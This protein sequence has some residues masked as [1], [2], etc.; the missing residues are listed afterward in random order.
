MRLL[1]ASAALSAARAFRSVPEEAAGFLGPFFAQV[2][3][4]MR[5]QPEG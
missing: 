2:A 5:N 3:D 4:F 1:I